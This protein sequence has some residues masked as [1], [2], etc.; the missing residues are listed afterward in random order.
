MLIMT[1]A[2]TGSSQDELTSASSPS[3]ES[4]EIDGQRALAPQNTLR[5]VAAPP[6]GSG[7]SAS[8]GLAQGQ[9]RMVLT[10]LAEDVT[11]GRTVR[12]TLLFRQAGELTLNVPVG[13][14][15]EAG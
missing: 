5:A 6:G 1:I 14:P 15:G 12:L 13:P 10:N 7:T 8:G 4:V 11:P 9:I 3:A 2:N